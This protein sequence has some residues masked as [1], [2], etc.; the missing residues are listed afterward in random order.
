LFVDLTDI[1]P[2]AFS[3]FLDEYKAQV[4]RE[5]ITDEARIGSLKVRLLNIIL[6]AS[7]WIFPIKNGIETIVHS[8]EG[9]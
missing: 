8:T 9:N 3:Y 5:N 6:K 2:A 4:K 1:T 7:D